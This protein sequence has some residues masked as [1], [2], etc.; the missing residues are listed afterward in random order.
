MGREQKDGNKHKAKERER[1]KALAYREAHAAHMKIWRDQ[2]KQFDFWDDAFW[3]W[4][5]RVE[6]TDSWCIQKRS[7]LYA[8]GVQPT[9]EWAWGSG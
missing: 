2:K 3:Q 6:S 8:W 7:H 1:H 4:N 9:L 5:S